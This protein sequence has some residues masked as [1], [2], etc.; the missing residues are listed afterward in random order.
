MNE[1]YF[2]VIVGLFV[3]LVPYALSY[4]KRFFSWLK[5]REDNYLDHRSLDSIH[6]YIRLII[7]GLLVFTIVAASVLLPPEYQGPFE[8]LGNY[9][10]IF[11]AFLTL[12][13]FAILAI[14]GSSAVAHYRKSAQ[15]DKSAVLKPGIMEFYELFIKYGMFALGTMV[16]V[17]VGIVTIPD[18]SIRSNIYDFMGFNTLDTARLGAEILSL[19]VLLIVIYVISKFLEIIL[20]DF[21]GRS[22]KFQ[23]GI[24]DLIKTAV[25]YSLYWIAFI[26]TLMVVL[27]MIW[28][29]IALIVVVFIMGLTGTVL[30]VIGVSPAAKNAISGI[31]LL[32]TDSINKGDWVQIGDGNTGEVISQGLALTS[33][34]TRSGDIIDLPNDTILNSKIHNFTKLGGTMVR[35]ALKLETELSHDNVELLLIHAAKGLDQSEDVESDLASL[36]V[37]ILNMDSQGVE[38]KINIWRKDPIT[39]ETAIS[40]FLK[41]FHDLSREKNIKVI[42]TRIIK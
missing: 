11:L 42:G 30:V 41:R 28:P 39:T 6:S 27:E 13:V 15:E 8:Y 35:L 7:I 26:I 31:V 33:L 40:D 1:L 38:Y 12:A 34:K 17:L 21:K 24:I 22:T 9:I 4:V 32:T 29:T 5:I 18:D 3:A 19:V 36:S 20:E 23:P 14:L 2:V 25:K 10:F 16:A 37:T